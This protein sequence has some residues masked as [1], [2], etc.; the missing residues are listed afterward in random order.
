MANGDHAESGGQASEQAQLEQ[1]GYEA[2]APQLKLRLAR[3][4]LPAGADV[5]SWVV[6]ADLASVLVHEL[7]DRWRSVTPAELE[8]WGWDHGE[9]QARALANTLAEPVSEHALVGPQ[10]QRVTVLRGDSPFVATR[11]LELRPW[12]QLEPACGLIVSVPNRHTLLSVGLGGAQFRLALTSIVELTEEFHRAGP[13][14]LSPALYF[15]HAGHL[16]PVVA[17]ID[18]DGLQFAPSAELRAA[19]AASGAEG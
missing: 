12:Q 6:G 11:L 17:L 1:L 9:V 10:G 14:P 2:L 5:V 16:E 4:P 13:G 3:K 8:R 19:L 7:P 15:L 18:E